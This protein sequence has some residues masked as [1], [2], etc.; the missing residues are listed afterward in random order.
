M[1]VTFEG[2]PGETG[3]FQSPGGFVFGV[4]GFNYGP[5][6]PTSIT[7]FLDNT[8]MVC[9][10]YGRPIRAA[11]LDDGRVLRFADAPPTA[12]EN[13]KVEPRPHFATHI[14]VVEALKSERIEWTSY[15]VKYRAGDG[16]T[17]VHSGLTKDQ[18]D[19]LLKEKSRDGSQVK[20]EPAIA[21]AGWPQLLYEELSKLPELPS[22]PLEELL[23]IRDPQLRK[24][25]IRI[26]READE[27]T[28]EELAASEE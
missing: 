10:Q 5:P 20:M 2:Q 18:A 1:A 6:R 19:K 11:M 24:D 28:A 8:A 27:A 13:N 26:R 15:I 9:D 23:K 21:C 4:Q 14:Q 3:E 17:K 12:D 7:W 25:A 22:T 16:R